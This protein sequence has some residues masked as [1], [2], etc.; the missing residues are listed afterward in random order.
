MKHSITPV[1]Y[2][3][4]VCRVVL[5]CESALICTSGVNLPGFLEESSLFDED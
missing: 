2:A 5:I 3:A 1:S 4:P